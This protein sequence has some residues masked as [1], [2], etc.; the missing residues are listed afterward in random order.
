MVGVA[1]LI[2]VVADVNLLLIVGVAVDV[3]CC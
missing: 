3:S 1:D 2:V